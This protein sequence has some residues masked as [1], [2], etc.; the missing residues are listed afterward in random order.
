M[1][2]NDCKLAALSL[3]EGFKILMMGSLEEAIAD[4]NKIP[5]DLPEVIDDFDIEEGEEVAIENK[6]V[7]LAKIDRR[8]KEYTVI[9]VI[10]L[11]YQLFL[12]LH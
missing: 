11:F 10:A 8:I 9:F 2:D 1:P 12:S 5:D 3:K 4:A 6:E 7:Y